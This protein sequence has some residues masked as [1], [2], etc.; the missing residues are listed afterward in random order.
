M[1]HYKMSHIYNIAVVVIM[2]MLYI[3]YS[4]VYMHIVYI[5]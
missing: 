5:S 1:A 3:M 4:N 2:Y